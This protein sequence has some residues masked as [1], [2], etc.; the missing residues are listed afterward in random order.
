MLGGVEGGGR[1]DGGGG[2][3]GRGC[4]G[5]GGG[6]STQRGSSGGR[7]GGRGEGCG[8][9]KTNVERNEK[10][11][12]AVHEKDTCRKNAYNIITLAQFATKRTLDGKNS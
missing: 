1:D 10:I 12:F 6:L 11:F 5:C 9:I 7:R 2:G 8:T 3:S 4:C